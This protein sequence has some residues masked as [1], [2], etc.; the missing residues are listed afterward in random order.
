MYEIT[1]NKKGASSIYN[2]YVQSVTSAKM[3]ANAK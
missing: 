1:P 2:Q 3:S